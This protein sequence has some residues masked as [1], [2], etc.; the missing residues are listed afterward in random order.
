MSAAKAKIAIIDGGIGGL[1]AALAL[2]RAGIDVEV[3]EQT[4]R[5]SEIGAGL[6]FSPNAL[7]ALRML[8]VE[9]E[10]IAAGYRDA[11]QVTRHFAT[12]AVMASQARD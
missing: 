1:A 8:D 9:D 4:T 11:R 2:H 10:A 5:I 7:L 6:N 12:G 3:Y